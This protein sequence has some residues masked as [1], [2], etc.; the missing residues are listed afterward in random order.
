MLPFKISSPFLMLKEPYPK[1]D[2]IL[3]I[4]QILGLNEATALSRLWLSEG[5]PFI[6]KDNPSIYEA[7]RGWIAAKLSIHPKQLT[8]I[9]SA[10]IGSSIAPPPKCNKP[11]S[12]ESDLDWA[13]ISKRLF[14]R[15]T[16]EFKE[17][18]NGYKKDLVH[19]RNPIE[20]KY[21]EDNILRCPGTIRRGFIDPYK[22]P[23]WGRFPISRLIADTM[24]RVKEKTKVT[25]FAPLF[26][27][28]T[29]RV[30]RDWCSFINLLT[31]NLRDAAEKL[32]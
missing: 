24:W 25:T 32:E 14:D 30:Y 18:E 17:W 13:A 31:L 11:F 21:W 2:S 12:P 4:V 9:G 6:F 15:C 7:I 3:R 19:P 10:R 5:I 27:K 23:T 26:K 8:L 28:S 1:G 16:T 20:A 22:I 29:I